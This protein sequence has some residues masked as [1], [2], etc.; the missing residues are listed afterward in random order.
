MGWS[1]REPCSDVRSGSDAPLVRQRA[2]AM[3][4][5][6]PSA[7]EGTDRA[8]LGRTARPPLRRSL[9][10]LA[11]GTVADLARISRN[12]LKRMQY[13]PELIAGSST[14]PDYDHHVHRP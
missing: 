8:G 14:R 13:R 2:A 5:T 11:A 7:V 9:A 3:F 6:G 4:A 12:R 10:N 1:E